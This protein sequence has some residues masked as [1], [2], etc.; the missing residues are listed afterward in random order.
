MI[1]IIFFAAKKGE[2]AGEDE[3]EP[4]RPT[5]SVVPPEGANEIT[6][7]RTN[8]RSVSRRGGRVQDPRSREHTDKAN[9]AE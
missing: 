7:G 3:A 2:G 5:D 8:A 6:G 4:K 9:Y 1:I